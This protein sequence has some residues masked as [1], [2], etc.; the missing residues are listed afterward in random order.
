MTHV[1]LNDLGRLAQVCRAW[2]KVAYD[3]SVW[4]ET[5]LPDG[6]PR[7]TAGLR[8]AYLQQRKVAQSQRAKPGVWQAAIALFNGALYHDAIAKLVQNG[9]LANSPQD[10]AHLLFADGVK[11]VAVGD[12]VGERHMVEIFEEFLLRFDFAGRSLHDA[13]QLLVAHLVLPASNSKIDHICRVFARRFFVQN[14]N[15]QFASADA[16]YMVSLMI[17]MLNTSINN[18]AGI[19]GRAADDE[20]AVC[21]ARRR[22]QRRQR[23]CQRL[24]RAAVQQRRAALVPAG[25]RGRLGRRR[26]G[27]GRLR[28]R[29]RRRRRG[30]PGRLGVV[31]DAQ[32]QARSPTRQ[33]DAD[34]DVVGG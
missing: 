3:D 15:A 7:V 27:L 9:A 11:Q 13:F 17:I 19:A 24:P 28:R 26:L 25:A 21:R 20:R 33:V 1:Q 32:Q 6:R 23:L 4:R 8:E 12:F 2:R 5:W 22:Q 29:R 18:A 30:R 10:L 16:V 34:C 31:V 14:A